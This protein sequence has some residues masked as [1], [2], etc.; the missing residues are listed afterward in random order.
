MNSQLIRIGAW[1]LLVA[2][3]VVTLGPIGLRPVSAAPVQLERLL[4]FGLLGL[5]FALAYPRHL[6]LVALLTF[7]A[8]LALEVFQYAVPGRHA[9]ASDF[10]AKIVGGGLGIA[11]GWAFARFISLRDKL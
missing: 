3:L 6:L 10:V 7:G 4:A 8:A 2:I 9:R 11:T 1:L 5:T